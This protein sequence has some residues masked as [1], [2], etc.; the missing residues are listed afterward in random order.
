MP[1]TR[2][3][4][5]GGR[6]EHGGETVHLLASGLVERDTVHSSTKLLAQKRV[7]TM[8][9]QMHCCRHQTST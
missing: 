8:A 3:D 6:F 4:Q 2:L 1:W 7:V 5:T 9:N